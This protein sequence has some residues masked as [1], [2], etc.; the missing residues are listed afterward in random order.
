MDEVLDTITEVEAPNPEPTVEEV[1]P[2]VEPIAKTPEVEPEQKQPGFVP[3]AAMLDER[4]KRKAAEQERTSLQEQLKS[5]EAPV[6][7]PDPYDDPEGYNQHTQRQIDQM[8]TAQRFNTSALIAK[9]AHGVEA[10]DAAAAWAEERAKTDPSFASMYMREEH[11]IE[12][13]VQQHKRDSLVS[14]LPTDVS[15]LDE[16]IEREIA[17][18]GLTAPIAAPAVQPVLKSAEPP[19]SIASDASPSNNTTSD[20]SAEFDAIFNRR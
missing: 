19:R 14:Q 17:K 18:R 1:T 8:M 4:D 7:V 15:S 10:V 6:T 2:A 12:W 9:Q 13:I 11:P 5:R 3:L 20:P 16:L